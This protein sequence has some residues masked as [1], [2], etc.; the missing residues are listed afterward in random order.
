M[1]VR[2]SATRQE[3][4]RQQEIHGMGENHHEL[5]IEYRISNNE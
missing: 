3:A 2:S 1:Y 5:N 4:A